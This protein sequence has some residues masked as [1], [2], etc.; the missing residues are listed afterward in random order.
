[1]TDRFRLDGRRAV[2]TGGVK[3]LGFAMACALGEA[4]AA[5]VLLDVDDEG[6]E[7]ARADATERRLA[8]DYM[9]C[10][11]T[12]AAQ[13]RECALR[14]DDGTPLVLVNNA[15][16]GGRI[17]DALETPVEEWAR[18]LDVNLS[19]VFSCSR[20][21]GRTMIAHR[22]G[23]IVNIAS[24]YGVVGVDGRLYAHEDG[25]PLENPA[26]AASKGGLVNL[27]RFLACAWARHG[28]RVNSISPGMFLTAQ[29]RPVVTPEVEARLS[30]RTP[31]GR[32]G[33]PDELGGAAVFLASDASS[34]VTGHNLVV[35]GGWTAW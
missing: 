18:T 4:G 27:T 32:L 22:R 5:V 20:E 14:C 10:D 19:A 24:V 16:V 17:L 7:A 21:F 33:D 2:V 29:S 26:Y 11:V 13:V 9:H 23:S 34:F 6:W 1:V 28:V 30:E 25:R 3:G 8:L 35:D 15:G 12:D 31:L